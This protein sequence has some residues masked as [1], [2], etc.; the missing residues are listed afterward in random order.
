MAKM[1]V[2]TQIW[3][4]CYAITENAGH[5]ARLVFGMESELNKWA[6]AMYQK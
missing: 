6:L 4:N 2:I 1:R 5:K 3:Q